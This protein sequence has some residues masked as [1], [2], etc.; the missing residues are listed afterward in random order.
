MKTQVK[1]HEIIDDKKKF[2]E[3]FKNRPLSNPFPAFQDSDLSSPV[4][5]NLSERNI[6]VG[7]ISNASA[8]SKENNDNE[9][10][11][12]IQI[13]IQPQE[14]EKNNHSNSNNNKNIN[15]KCNCAIDQ[16]Q[17]IPLPKNDVKNHVK[18]ESFDLI[19]L[20]G[21][22]SFGQVFLVIIFILK[23]I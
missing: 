16:A 10:D 7:P 4:S 8:N 20:I 23:T 18:F 14:N 15:T 2:T 17:K 21:K 9:S 11:V 1:N 12:Q 3:N 19:R 5:P 6:S 22:G 13:S